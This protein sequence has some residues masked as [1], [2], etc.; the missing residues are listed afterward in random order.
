[1][2][3]DFRRCQKRNF[4]EVWDCKAKNVTK[5]IYVNGMSIAKALLFSKVKRF[6]G[7]VLSSS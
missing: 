2:Y 6:I 5:E 3:H 4:D 1:M 7:I